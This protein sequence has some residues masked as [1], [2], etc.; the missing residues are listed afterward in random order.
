MSS[1]KAGKKDKE[2][3]ALKEK[4]THE[5]VMVSLVCHGFSQKLIISPIALPPQ[6]KATNSATPSKHKKRKLDEGVVKTSPIRPVESEGE[7]EDENYTLK[8]T[9]S[10][11]RD[12]YWTL[13]RDDMVTQLEIADKSRKA[14]HQLRDEHYHVLQVSPAQHWILSY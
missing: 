4:N 13:S 5:K 11:Q 2:R 14:F 7:D 8:G 6:S 1:L 9:S 12:P 3:K 10:P